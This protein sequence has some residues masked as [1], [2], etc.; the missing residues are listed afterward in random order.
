MVRFKATVKRTKK[1]DSYRVVIPMALVKHGIV[2]ERSEY[3]FTM[4]EAD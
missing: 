1:K 4:E 3:W 2:K